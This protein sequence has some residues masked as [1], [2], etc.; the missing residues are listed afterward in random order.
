MSYHVYN[1]ANG[2]ENIFRDEENYRF[3]LEQLFQS[4][5]TLEELSY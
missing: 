2:T 3:L 5:K 1:H 4:S